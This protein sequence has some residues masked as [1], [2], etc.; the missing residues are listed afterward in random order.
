M[1]QKAFDLIVEKV[2]EA[3]AEQG[4]GGQPQ[5][6][7]EEKGR[8]ALFVGE[9]VAYSVLYNRAQ[10]RFELRT[11]AMTDE[12]PDGK[13]K[14]L[15]SW[16]FDPEADDLASAS[17]IVNDFVDTVQGPKRVAA[18]QQ[19]KK[20]RKKDEDST[21]D[22]QFFFNRLS[23][24]FPE[25]R[26][27]MNAEKTVYGEVRPVTFARKSVVPKVEA[28]ALNYPESEPFKK[29]CTLFNDLYMSG[30]MDVRSL[31][32]IVILNGV[33]DQKALAGMEELFSDDLK[34]VYAKAKNFRGK[35]V[36]PE[37]KKKLPRYDAETLNSLRRS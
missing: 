19:A 28:L 33:S 29:L 18:V 36:K 32:T 4:F 30:D 12:G 25:L 31:I 6:I 22:P 10:K 21:S 1:E 20:K 34:R 8:A 17:S 7:K 5:E 27:E 9:N 16:L 13:W 11:C 35:K 3:L 15:S 37:K 26:D 23:G 2:G 24:I 14:N